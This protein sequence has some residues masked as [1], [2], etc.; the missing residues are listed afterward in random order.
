[1]NVKKSINSFRDNLRCLL[2]RCVWREVHRHTKCMCR[3]NSMKSNT[4]CH[5]DGDAFDVGVS[6]ESDTISFVIL[7]HCVFAAATELQIVTNCFWFRLCIPVNGFHAAVVCCGQY[8]IRRLCTIASKH[9]SIFV[10]GSHESM[11]NIPKNSHKARDKY[12]APCAHSRIYLSIW[13]LFGCSIFTRIIMHRKR[14][15]KKC[16]KSVL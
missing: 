8:R 3:F 4:F 13:S 16:L 11:Q 6:S 9:C 7:D 10:C 5:F 1:M 12:C 14:E 2:R 15:Q